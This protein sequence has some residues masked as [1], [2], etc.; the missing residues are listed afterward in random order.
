MMLIIAAF[1]WY[2]N[3]VLA[4][5]LAAVLAIVFVA[6]FYVATVIMRGLPSLDERLTEDDTARRGQRGR[7]FDH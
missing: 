6:A 7:G 5:S 4:A 1:A 2:A 3:N